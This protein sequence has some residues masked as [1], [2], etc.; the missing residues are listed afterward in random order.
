MTRPAPL[1]DV[2]RTGAPTLKVLYLYLQPLGVVEL[3][4]REL[5]EL[6][7]VSLRPLNEAFTVLERH[8]LLEYEGERTARRM[9]PYRIK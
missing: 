1:P 7:G 2:V 3:T 6:L 5:A 8:E 9:T 4:R